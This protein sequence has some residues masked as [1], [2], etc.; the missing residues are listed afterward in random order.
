MKLIRFVLG[1]II[2]FF[3]AVFT[4]ALLVHRSPADQARVD[5]ETQTWTLYHLMT[6]PF[7]VK[8][9][10]EM[11]RLGV[12]IPLKDVGQDP[13]AF[14]ELMNGGKEDQVP[15]LKMGDTWMYESSEINAFL[16]QRFGK[17]NLQESK[18]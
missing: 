1:K 8:V 5:A 14:Q 6:C 15:C 4:P 10:R 13:Q 12:T 2:L 18:A 11:K 16:Q 9:R 3:D 7:C 17:V